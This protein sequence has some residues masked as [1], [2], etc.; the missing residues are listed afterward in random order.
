MFALN[1]PRTRDDPTDGRGAPV[2]LQ[3]AIPHLFA[4]FFRRLLTFGA[5]RSKTVMLI[6]VY[7]RLAPSTPSLVAQ[8]S[9]LW[10]DLSPRLRGHDAAWSGGMDTHRTRLVSLHFERLSRERPTLPR[11]HGWLR[12]SAVTPLVEMFS[13]LAESAA[14]PLFQPSLGALSRRSQA[15]FG[16]R[17][18]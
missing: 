18:T 13:P 3:R 4:L 16:R 10:A 14:S 5:L 6:A 15:R 12:L 9:L 11:L 2:I 1:A 7:V 17:C 8:T